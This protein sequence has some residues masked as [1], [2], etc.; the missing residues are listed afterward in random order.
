MSWYADIITF[1]NRYLAHRRAA[2]LAT[3]IVSYLTLGE[4]PNRSV[5]IS[6]ALVTMGAA[7]SGFESL[8]FTTS[9][10]DLVLV[11]ANNLSQSLQVTYVSKHNKAG[12]ITPFGKFIPPARIND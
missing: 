2:I 12:T 1:F 10:L 6:T 11:W 5:A 4:K 7:V 9:A 8:A 3:V